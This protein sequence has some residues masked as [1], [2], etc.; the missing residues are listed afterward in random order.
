MSI[1]HII[2][3]KYLLTKNLKL[4]Q[5]RKEVLRFFLKSERHLSVEELYDIIKKKNPTIGHTTV[6]RTL[7]LLCD[8]DIAREVNFADKI[9]RYEHKYG[10]EHHDHLICLK[11]GKFVEAMDP[12]I[13]ELQ[14]KLCEQFGFIPIKHRMEIFGLCQKC[15]KKK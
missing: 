10:H 8:A 9:I 4:T 12:K 14:I 7:K 6:F 3:E 11:C 1:E 5:Q 13:E 15:N 2:F